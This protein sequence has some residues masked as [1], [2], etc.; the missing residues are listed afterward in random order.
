M[1]SGVYLCQVQV[2]LLHVDQVVSDQQLHSLHVVLVLITA[3]N[4][5]PGTSKD[6]T[7]INKLMSGFS[8]PSS[9]EQKT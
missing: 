9:F 6:I 1:C 7:Y 8:F 2:V 3:L 5:A 4:Q